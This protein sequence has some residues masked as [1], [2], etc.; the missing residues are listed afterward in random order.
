M[1]KQAL[2]D[3]LNGVKLSSE[4]YRSQP[5]LDQVSQLLESDE[6]DLQKLKSLIISYGIPTSQRATIWKLMLGY[7]PPA[8]SQWEETVR[9]KRATYKA[10][11]AAYNESIRSGSIEKKK[12][13]KDI[14]VD[15][16]RSYIEGYQGVCGDEGVRMAVKRMLYVWASNDAIGYYQGMM[17]LI[18]AVFIVNLT[19][20]ME[21]RGISDLKRFVGKIGNEERVEEFMGNVEADTFYCFDGL[22]K[23]LGV[24][25]YNYFKNIFK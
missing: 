15:I 1:N 5:N 20:G 3:A 11:A 9:A 10:R 14:S 13:L 21:D 24:F 7:L 25:I 6:I 17:D 23:F 22:M 16:P 18:Y 12:V 4:D 2:V 8:R 19:E